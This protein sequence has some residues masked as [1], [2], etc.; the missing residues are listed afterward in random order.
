[1]RGSARPL[2][3]H[4][5]PPEP[6]LSRAKRSATRH[7]LTDRL[8]RRVQGLHCSTGLGLSILCFVVAYTHSPW[9]CKVRVLIIDNTVRESRLCILLKDNRPTPGVIADRNLVYVQNF[10]PR[11]T[12]VL[13]LDSNGNPAC[14]SALFVLMARRY[15]MISLFSCASYLGCFPTHSI[16]VFKLFFFTALE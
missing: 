6:L 9:N 10:T 3:G 7:C 2:Y 5:G 16:I 1:M 15:G 14:K 4:T 11:R 8:G 12:Y 13:F